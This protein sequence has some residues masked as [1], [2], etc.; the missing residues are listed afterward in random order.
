VIIKLVA[1]KD[2]DYKLFLP[3]HL[4]QTDIG[5][6][7]LE[8]DLDFHQPKSGSYKYSKSHSM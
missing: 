7:F 5:I 6:I 8:R 1:H 3:K 2:L 4:L